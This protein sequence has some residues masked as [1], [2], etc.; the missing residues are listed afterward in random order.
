MS[1][2][3][4]SRPCPIERLSADSPQHHYTLGID[5]ER[6]SSPGVS[7]PRELHDRA[8]RR[9]EDQSLDSFRFALD[10]IALATQNGD[11]RY[12]G[13]DVEIKYAER[14]ARLSPGT[15]LASRFFAS[16]V[17]MQ[18]ILPARIGAPSLLPVTGR[19]NATS[20]RLRSRPGP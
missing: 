19:R 16:S 9:V 3:R 4:R 12:R 1:Y 20:Q 5:G 10:A 14:V 11:L 2:C 7:E 6:I 13:H 15:E 18:E 17:T 8:A